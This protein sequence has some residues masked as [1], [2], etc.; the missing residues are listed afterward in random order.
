MGWFLRRRKPQV[1]HASV[2]SRA[3]SGWVVGEEMC[4]TS[5]MGKGWSV[6]PML[7]MLDSGLHKVS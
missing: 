2:I 4:D 7:N 5:I 1:E 3:M 6:E